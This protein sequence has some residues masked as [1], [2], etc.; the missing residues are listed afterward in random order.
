M[1]FAIENLVAAPGSRGY[2]SSMRISELGRLSGVDPETIRYYEKTG[3]MPPPH[4]LGNGYRDYGEAHVER[5]AFIRQCRGLDMNL[6][7]VALLLEIA[8][9]PQAECTDVDHLI[10]DHLARVR[11]RIRG[12]RNLEK[13]LAELRRCCS[14]PRRAADCGILQELSIGA[15]EDTRMGASVRRKK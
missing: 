11:V 1:N 9:H 14:T 2:I 13:Q 5:L 12:L 6:K 3:L 10:D 8:D 7:E 4:R 15:R